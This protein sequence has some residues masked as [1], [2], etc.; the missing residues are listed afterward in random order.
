M[1]RPSDPQDPAGRH[2]SAG[3]L[4]KLRPGVRKTEA[5]GPREA[6]DDLWIKCPDTGE[7]IFRSDLEAAHFVT[8]SG[9]HMRITPEQRFRYTFDEGRFERETAPQATDDPLGFVDQKPYAQRLAAAREATGETDA[10][11]IA[12]GTIKGAPAVMMVQNFAFLGGSLGM[13]AGEGFIAAARAALRR[14]V[15]LVA[16]TASGGARMQ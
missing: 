1:A 4:S 14:K 9:F 12:A 5:A 8:P 16:A 15:P 7:L 3:W 2:R 11:S 13:S 10:V 6:P